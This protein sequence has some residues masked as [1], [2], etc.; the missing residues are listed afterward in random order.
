MFLTVTNTNASEFT[1]MSSSSFSGEDQHFFCLSPWICSSPHT[2]SLLCH[3]RISSPFCGQMHPRC[4]FLCHL[5][6]KL[7]L[8][9]RPNCQLP[10]RNL[11]RNTSTIIPVAHNVSAAQLSST[12]GYFLPRLQLDYL[13][14]CFQG[15]K[16][17]FRLNRT[18]QTFGEFILK[19]SLA[20]CGLFCTLSCVLPVG[21]VP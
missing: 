13:I 9:D 11:Q 10:K 8:S 20:V 21:K 5:C 6:S 1:L 14:Y 7:L 3:L 18:F 15:Q 16:L 17:S 19:L 12:S 2:R 4:S